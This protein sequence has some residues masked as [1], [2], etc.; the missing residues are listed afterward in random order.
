MRILKEN[1]LYFVRMYDINIDEYVTKQFLSNEEFLM[2]LD[3]VLPAIVSPVR[4]A[5]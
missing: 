1:G 2:W 3:K 5:E 4:Q